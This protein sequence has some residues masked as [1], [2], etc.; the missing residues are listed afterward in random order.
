MRRG[1]TRLTW[2]APVVGEAPTY[3]TCPA[4]QSAKCLSPLKCPVMQQT[5]TR[6]SCIQFSWQVPFTMESRQDA[7]FGVYLQLPKGQVPRTNLHQWSSSTEWAAR[8]CTTCILAIFPRQPKRE[9]VPGYPT[10]IPVLE[11]V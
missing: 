7:R 10:L 4:V 6:C 1:L 11:A 8:P 5:V 2:I 3:S 9:K